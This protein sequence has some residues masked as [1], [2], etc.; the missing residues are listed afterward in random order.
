LGRTCGQR[1][2]ILSTDDIPISIRILFWYVI[3]IICMKEQIKEFALQCGAWHQVYDHKSLMVDHKFDV[4]KFAELIVKDCLSHMEEGD[5]DFAIW[6][7]KKQ[8]GIES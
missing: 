8:Y 7:I 5:I 4:E 3:I 6:S 1:T 2:S